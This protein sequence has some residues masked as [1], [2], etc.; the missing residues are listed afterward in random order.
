MGFREENQTNL[1]PRGITK[2]CCSRKNKKELWF[3]KN[4]KGIGFQD[5][6]INERDFEMKNKGMV[7]GKKYQRNVVPDGITH[8]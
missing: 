8:R 6:E 1:V 7:L 2:E 3:Q 4:N 5:E